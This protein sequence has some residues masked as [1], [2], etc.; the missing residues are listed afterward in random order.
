MDD[1]EFDRALVAACFVMAGERGWRRMRV[2]DAARAAGL[3][4]ERARLRCPGRVAVLLRFGRIADQAALAATPGEGSCRDRLF[5][6]LMH[7]IDVLQA[8]R[9]GVLAL[10]KALPCDPRLA[11]LLGAATLRSMGWMLGAAGISAAGPLGRLRAKA[12]VAVWLWTVR[13]WRA[14]DSADLAATMAALDQALTRAGEL[15]SWLRRKPAA[16]VAAAES[17][18]SDEPFTP[19]SSTEEPPAPA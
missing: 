16:T 17:P 6:L 7:R 5:D 8:H 4:L 2:A 19:D 11:L 1:A 14:D 18:P 9:A 10:L 15:Q 13:A 3:P 12:L